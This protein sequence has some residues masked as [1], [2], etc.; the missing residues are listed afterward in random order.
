MFEVLSPSGSQ[1]LIFP[2]GGY[3][4]GPDDDLEQSTDQV[5]I[6]GFAGTRSIFSYP[7][8]NV[9]VRIDLPGVPGQDQFRM[10]LRVEDPADLPGLEAI[11]SSLLIA[12]SGEE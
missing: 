5:I 10:E 9:L 12:A 4:Y 7:N 8:G 2:S 11:L 3:G 1:F 6:D